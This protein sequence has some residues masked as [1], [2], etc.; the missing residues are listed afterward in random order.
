[1]NDELGN[2]MK[3]NY[4]DRTRFFLPRRTYTL[5]RVDGKAFHTLTKHFERPFDMELMSIMNM[6]AKRLCEEIQGAKLAYVQSDEISVLLTDFSQFNTSAWFDGNVQKMASISAAIATAE[7]NKQFALAAHEAASHDNGAGATKYLTGEYGQLKTGYFD[8]RVFTIPDP[9]E[10]ENY[11]IWRQGDATRNSV[12]MVARSLYSHS[13]LNGKSNAALQD[14]I[15]AKG[16]NWNDYPAGCKR[17]RCIVREYYQTPIPRVSE[18][19]V[20]PESSSITRSCWTVV[21]PPIFTQ[22]RDFLRKIIP[23]ISE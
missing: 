3:D 1:M 18:F 14:M 17:G 2:R 6:V 12:Q 21:E 13:E 11:F 19:G 22:D 15:H 5:I 8:S 4:E 7:F 20:D 10:V 9:I 23:K 16:K